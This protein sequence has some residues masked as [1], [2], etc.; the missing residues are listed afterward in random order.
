MK[1]KAYAKIN[2]TLDVTGKLPDGYHTIESVMQSV[3]LCDDV[4]IEKNDT[5]KVTTETNIPYLPVNEKN[6][7]WK[8]ANSFFK[9]TGIKDGIHI[10]VMKN[11]PDRAGMGGGS[12]DAAAVLHGMNRIYG[13]MLSEQ[14]L[15]E[16]GEEV[17]ADVPFCVAGGTCLCAGK[18]EQLQPVPPMPDCVLVICKPSVGMS[19]LRAYAMIDQYP[20]AQP[21]TPQMLAALETRDIDKI[22]GA[23]ANRFDEVMHISEVGM[24]KSIMKRSGA[25]GALMTGSGS[26]VYGIF[27]DKK[28]AFACMEKLKKQGRVYI[29]R[30]ICFEEYRDTVIS[31]K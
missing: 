19:T 25:V 21:K 24:I 16:I 27:K 30:P 4:E 11:I 26:A 18:G 5:G 3:S 7:V 14:K 1:I 22:A 6:T 15:C 23:I 12:A 10:K 2:L 17:G 28:R 31:E 20:I 13:E 29:T 8:A 9:H